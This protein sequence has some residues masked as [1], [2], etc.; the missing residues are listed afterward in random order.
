MISGG[1]STAFEAVCDALADRIGAEREIVAGRGHAIP[2]VGG[3]YNSRVHEFLKRA[4][5]SA[6]ERDGD[7]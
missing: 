2:A 7:D 3:A 5:V 6:R 1:H 4:E